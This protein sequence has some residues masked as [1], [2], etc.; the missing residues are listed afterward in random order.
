[1]LTL[2]LSKQN[3][4]PYF[5]KGPA[6]SFVFNRE[7]GILTSYQKLG[8]KYFV[9]SSSNDIYIFIIFLG[10]DLKKRL[11]RY[12]FTLSKES[13]PETAAGMSHSNIKVR[14]FP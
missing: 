5:T 14:L 10:N 9:G 8:S 13:S 2:Y 4:N 1:M 11:N 12:H 3:R 7:S 6:I